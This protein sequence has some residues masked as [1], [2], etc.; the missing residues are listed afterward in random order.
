[1]TQCGNCRSDW[2]KSLYIPDRWAAA[3]RYRNVH[4]NTDRQSFGP[5]YRPRIEFGDDQIARLRSLRES[6]TRSKELAAVSSPLFRLQLLEL[7]RDI[8]LHVVRLE[9]AWRIKQDVTAARGGSIPAP[10]VDAH[11]RAMS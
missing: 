8:E 11:T 4:M 1:M 2:N 6:V 10:P 3:Q 7:A 5:S 9:V